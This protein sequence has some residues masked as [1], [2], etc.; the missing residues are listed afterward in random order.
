VAEALLRRRL[1]KAGIEAHV[2]SAG[3]LRSG[4]AAS[5]HG[6]DVLSERGID[7]AAHRSRTMTTAMLE[8]ADLIVAMAR[9]HVREAVV[10]VPA[11]FPRTFTLKELVRRGH[12]VGHR[13][14]GQTLDR[15]LDNVNAG[16]TV[17]GLMGASPSDDVADPIGLPRPAYERMVAD[18]EVLV[19]E[20]VGLVWGDHERR[21]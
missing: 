15:W 8:G 12:E 21:R 3:L 18:L 19:D 20:M 6:V 9:E 7:I 10:T 17:G 5:A 14:P 16:R 2:H 1:E 4:L 13:L 11:V